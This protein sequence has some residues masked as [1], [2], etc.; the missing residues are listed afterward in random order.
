MRFK[1]FFIA[2]GAYPQTVPPPVEHIVDV[3]DFASVEYALAGFTE[4]DPRDQAYW[5]LKTFRKSNFS[6]AKEFILTT[7]FNAGNQIISVTDY[8]VV[9]RDDLQVCKTCTSC[10]VQYET[11]DFYSSPF[12]LLYMEATTFGFVGFSGILQG[13]ITTASRD[14][15]SFGISSYSGTMRDAI[16]GITLPRDE[17]TFGAIS[18]TGTMAEAVITVPSNSD[19]VTFGA[20]GYT[21]TM[22]EALIQNAIPNER[23]SFGVVS[24]TAT[25]YQ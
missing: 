23:V 21:G 17:V 8:E 22:A 20:I 25:M 7:S 12:P 3:A 14:D 6:S 2:N 4:T 11:R 24:Y 19:N 1:I 18:Y 9:H 5:A 16:L 15:L 13:G 10:E